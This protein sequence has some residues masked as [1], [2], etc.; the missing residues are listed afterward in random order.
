MRTRVIASATVVL[1]AAAALLL[2]VIR[3]PFAVVAPAP[4]LRSY[5]DVPTVLAGP[6]FYASPIAAGV[7]VD[8][9]LRL[10]EQ[11]VA[12]RLWLGPSRTGATAHARI[13]LLA[14]P[15]GPSLRSGE[16]SLDRPSGTI[17][18]RIVPPLRSSELGDDGV[19]LL[20]LA[21][22]GD[23]GPIR[24]GMAKGASYDGGRASIGGELKY[25]DQDL[26]FEVARQP[27]PGGVWSAALALIDSET[28][29]L[30]SAAAFG[31]IVLAAILA[32]G[33]LART[34]R[35]PLALTVAAVAVVA[36][37]LIVLDRTP[38]SVFPGPDFNPSVILR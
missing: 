21:P 17:V 3:Q 7:V 20:R 29:P 35:L 30:R 34:R 15:H 38:L 8:Q 11:D 14:G 13:E 37:C 33:S 32:A 16:I 6:A 2:V 26:M 36:G 23:S 10:T 4:E 22:T 5:G 27:S 24:V 9:E 18:A 25:E 31:P 19:T 12:V 28:L 1:L